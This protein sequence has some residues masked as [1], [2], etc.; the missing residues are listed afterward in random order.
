MRSIKKEI[1]RPW[2][3]VTHEN[4]Y[5]KPQWT[6]SLSSPFWIKRRYTGIQGDQFYRRYCVNGSTYRTKVFLYPSKVFVKSVS[7]L[8]GISSFALENVTSTTLH[9]SP[10]WRYFDRRYRYP[11]Y[12]TTSSNPWPNSLTKPTKVENKS[13]ESVRG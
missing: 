1:R 10:C 5:V 12:F 4:F 3:R 13:V 6:D 2:T 9:D 11:T 7:R 8:F